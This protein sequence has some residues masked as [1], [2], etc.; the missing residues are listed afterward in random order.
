VPQVATTRSSPGSRTDKRLDVTLWA[1]T[2]AC[3]A[4]TLWFSFVQAP[5]GGDLFTGADKVG[6][7]LAYFATTLSFLFAVVWRPGRGE[8]R[9]PRLGMWVPVAAVAL[10]A[11]IELLQGLT[12]KRT[13]EV[14]DVLAE[15]VGAVLALL[16]HGT[17]R[18]RATSG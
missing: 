18:W 1:T 16:V 14:R 2:A 3:L 10:G 9:W 5:P 12:P 11:V 8:G 7:G 15:A 6:H 13:P 17:I 4:T